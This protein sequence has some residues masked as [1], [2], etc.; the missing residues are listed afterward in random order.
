MKTS[1]ILLIIL[2]FLGIGA[3]IWVCNYGRDFDIDC[4]DTIALEV[5]Q[6]GGKTR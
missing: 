5:C 2:L 3:L 4:L 1:N 6:E